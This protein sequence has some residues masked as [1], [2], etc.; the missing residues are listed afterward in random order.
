MIT[1]LIGFLGSSAFGSITGSLFAWLNKREERAE[2]KAKHEHEQAMA[3][4]NNA[5]AL[6][7]ADK[8]REGMREA[9]EQAV[10]KAEA[11]AFVVSQQAANQKPTG[12]IAE[13]I[14]SSVRPVITL[15]LLIA[16]TLITIRLGRI[17]GGF[18]AIP[19]V[20][21]LSIWKSVISELL[22]L[23]GYAVGWWFGARGSSKKK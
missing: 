5:Q 7:L 22:A 21:V 4:I 13:I 3:T 19:I 2:L 23:T 11:D 10:Y 1:T 6:A 8:A 14:W 15:W 9:G 12:K 20:D 17:I 18:D 16:T